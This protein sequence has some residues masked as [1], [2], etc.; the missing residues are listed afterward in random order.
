MTEWSAFIERNLDQRGITGAKLAELAGF[1]KSQVTA[2]RQRGSAPSVKNARAAAVALGVSVVEAFV[3]AGF[4][5][6]ADVDITEIDRPL[7]DRADDELMREL[8]RRLALSRSII[9]AVNAILARGGEIP[10]RPD[11]TIDQ[12]ALMHAPERWAATA[13]E[14]RKNPNLKENDNGSFTIINPTYAAS[15]SDASGKAQREDQEVKRGDSSDDVESDD[16]GLGVLADHLEEDVVGEQGQRGQV[17]G[18]Q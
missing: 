17:S 11:G 12:H 4:M 10:T 9:H 15:K 13:E 8:A 7:T 16:I 3:A 1:D 2:W 18:G 5:E 14:A 6:P